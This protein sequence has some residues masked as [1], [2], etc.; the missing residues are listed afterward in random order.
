MSQGNTFLQHIDCML[1]HV[2]AKKNRL[3]IEWADLKEWHNCTLLDTR[4]K[5][6]DQ[7]MNNDLGCTGF[8]W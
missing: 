6:A 8:Q 7:A 4:C 3:G 1:W 2:P 5:S